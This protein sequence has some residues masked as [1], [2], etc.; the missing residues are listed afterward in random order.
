MPVQIIQGNS[1]NNDFARSVFN[2]IITHPE[3]PSELSWY[4]SS[5]TPDFA[6]SHKKA[7]EPLARNSVAP[8]W[9]LPMFGSSEVMRLSQ[10]KGKVVLL[11]FWNKNCGYCISAVPKLNALAEKFPRKDFIVLGVNLHDRKED[12]DSFYQKNRPNYRTVLDGGKVAEEYGID[13]YP[14]VVLI[15]K[16]GKV[17]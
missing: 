1:V 9:Q 3:N 15:D 12:V 16:Q 13:A 2:N 14:V 17:I 11:E 6:L 4:Y 5:Y 10:L 7:L 8:D